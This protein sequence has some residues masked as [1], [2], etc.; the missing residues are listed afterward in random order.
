MRLD[1]ENLKDLDAVNGTF[2]AST[3]ILMNAVETS[4]TPEDSHS[5]DFKI[6]MKNTLDDEGEL[7]HTSRQT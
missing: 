3:K 7:L 5:Y 1:W 2:T 6:Q 4:Y